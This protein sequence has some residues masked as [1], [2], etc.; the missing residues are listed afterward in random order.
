MTTVPSPAR[1]DRWRAGLVC[2]IALAGLYAPSSI[3]GAISES[4]S[5]ASI[6]V[7]GLG[8]LVLLIGSAELGSRTAVIS[9][10]GI[11]FVLAFATSLSP[12][13]TVPS[14]LVALFAILAGIC[15]LRLPREIGPWPRRVFV[16]VS[17][18]SFVAGAL[19]VMNDGWIDWIQTSWFAAFRPTL[20]SSM[21]ESAKPVLTFATHS[22]AAFMFYLLFFMGLE[23]WRVTGRTMFLVIMAGYAALLVAL[24]STTAWLLLIVAVLQT[25]AAVWD[26]P[27]RRRV[28]IAVATATVVGLGAWLWWQ[29]VGDGELWRTRLL[30]NH[31]HGFIARYSADGLLAPNVRYLRSLAFRPIGL[32]YAPTL[33]L[34]D[35][36]L[37]VSLLRGSWLLLIAVYA[38]LYGMFRGHV[39]RATAVWLCLVIAA[40]ELGFTPLQY[41]R[42]LAFVPFLA[43]Y[44]GSLQPANAAAPKAIDARALF[45]AV[46]RRWWMVVA[47]GGLAAMLAMAWQWMRPPTYRATVSFRTEQSSASDETRRAHVTTLAYQT[48]ENSELLHSLWSAIPAPARRGLT[49]DAFRFS[50]LQVAAIN[51]GEFLQITVSLPDAEWA[52]RT[53]TQVADVIGARSAAITAAPGRVPI[54]RRSD[55]NTE[56]ARPEAYDVRL[57]LYGTI[58]GVLAMLGALVLLVDTA[59]APDRS[60]VL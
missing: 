30:G 54:L 12:F 31:D 22:M 56:V 7:I 55:P 1:H 15:C 41:F 46:L 2:V 40:F 44:L 32:T 24:N 10:I 17:A 25:L 34:A 11:L 3:G 28:A 60:R 47:A 33:Y 16:I 52:E 50:A 4:L 35:S 8:V 5:I 14:G 13:R 26:V 9:A 37:I 38:G 51:R 36:G 57:M 53:A 45:R 23:T 39:S 59:P 48:R 18:I 6:S 21:V 19:T 20:V 27:R 29:G 58:S 42:F 49:E 43:M